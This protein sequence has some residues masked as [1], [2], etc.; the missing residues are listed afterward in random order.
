VRIIKEKFLR[1]AAEQYPKAAKYLAA[2][3]V[4]VRAARCA[5]S[6]APSRVAR[7]GVVMVAVDGHA[8]RRAVGLGMRSASRV[9]VLNGLSEGDLVLAEGQYALPDGT[10][11]EVVRDPS[12]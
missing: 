5:G 4:T 9:E 3:T 10:A 1:D 6:T 7:R 11:I 2:W 8:Q 12:E